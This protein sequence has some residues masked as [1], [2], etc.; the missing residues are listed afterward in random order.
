MINLN[1]RL[2]EEASIRPSDPQ[3][4]TNISMCQKL[5]ASHKYLTLQ[6]DVRPA[7]DANFPCLTRHSRFTV[8][9]ALMKSQKLVYT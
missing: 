2:K 1:A 5:I 6:D 8:P 9:P 7:V 3:R 4:A